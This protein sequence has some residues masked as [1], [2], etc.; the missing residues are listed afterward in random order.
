MSKLKING[1]RKA[2]ADADSVDEVKDIGNIAMAP[3]S[4]GRQTKDKEMVHFDAHPLTNAYPM[5]SGAP[6]GALKASI[7]EHGLYQPVVLF[8]GLVLDGRNR[9]KACAELGITPNLVD[10]AGDSSP[11]ALAAYVRAM[12]ERRD[13]TPQQRAAALLIHDE[14]MAMQREAA[15]KRQKTGKGPKGSGGRGKKKNP[16]QKVEQG[17]DPNA[18]KTNEKI[19]KMA[20]TNRQY[21]ADLS[22]LRDTDRDLFEL[23]R[24]GKMKIP[25]AKRDALDRH[26]EKLC[27]EAKVELFPTPEEQVTLHHATLTQA[28][29]EPGSIADWIITK[30][31]SGKEHVPLY[32][33]LAKVAKHLLKP[34]GVLLCLSEQHQLSHLVRALDRHL[35][36]CWML[37]YEV[38]AGQSARIFKR[39]INTFWKPVLMYC[40]GKYRGE[41]FG[42]LVRSKPNETDSRHHGWGHYETAMY[43]LMNRFVKPGQHVVDPFLGDGTTG[44]IAYH[45]G[46]TF[47]GYDEDPKAI[48]KTWERL[49]GVD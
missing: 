5:M 30:P 34:D 38:P 25:K 2:L 43:N 4:D 46:A 12:N 32:Y 33:R 47:E 1:E 36:Y 35:T 49:R 45:L 41:C 26:R 21:V 40:K 14:W 11:D 37:T 10:Y 15:K 44:V 31:P 23:V 17:L 18:N 8:N 27:Q 29:S 39:D 7:A 42:D 20:G 6:F 28:R 13:L 24:V 48:A 22:K 3:A 16:V 19:A 9:L